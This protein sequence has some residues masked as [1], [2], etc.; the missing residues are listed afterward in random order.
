MLKNLNKNKNKNKRLLIALMST[1]MLAVVP[2]IS[3]APISILADEV[4][5]EITG[6]WLDVEGVVGG[7]I[8]FDTSSGSITLAEAS[9]TSANIPASINGVA[10]TSIDEVAFQF[11][12]NLTTLTIPSSVATISYNSFQGTS[13][14]TSISV[15]QNNANFASSGGVLFNKD[16]TKLIS[17]PAGNTQTSYEIPTSVNTIGDYAFTDAINL[18]NISIPSSVTSINSWVFHN[19]KALTNVVFPNSVTSIGDGVFSNC[20]SL[21][22]VTLPDSTS[23]ITDYLFYSCTSLSSINIPN[24]VTSIGNASFYNCTSLTN[25]DIPNGVTSIGDATFYN[26]TNINTLSIPTSVTSIGSG[27]ISNSSNFNNILYAGTQEQWNAIQIIKDTNEDFLNANITYNT[28]ITNTQDTN[29]SNLPFTDIN[30][31]SDYFKGLEYLFNNGIITG[32]SDTTFA[33]SGTM[34][35]ASLVTMLH[36]MEDTPTAPPSGFED[37]QEGQWYTNAIDWAKETG[38]VNGTS[39]T[40]FSPDVSLTKES[41]IAIIDRYYDYK[42]YS[43]ETTMSGDIAD[44]NSASSWFQENITNMYKI[45]ILNIDAN[46]NFN[47]TANATRSDVAYMLGEFLLKVNSSI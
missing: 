3:L 47:P 34:T 44:L 7:K 29:T 30:A 27:I 45:G 24:S 14:L 23:K 19:A 28:S 35:R 43:L 36:R 46:N 40:T 38:L 25:L 37:V 33:P 20:I 31:N 18:K 16:L 6:E 2:N 22:S 17:Y 39:D 8:N 41:V 5:D 13:S 11:C 1:S 15:D 4:I 9:I 42:Q 26:N 21:T 32:T 12:E 10:V